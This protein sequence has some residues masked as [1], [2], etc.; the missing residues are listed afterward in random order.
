MEE[1]PSH[2]NFIPA[3][4]QSAVHTIESL[5][6]LVE[7]E[8]ELGVVTFQLNKLLE[9]MSV[10]FYIL[11]VEFPFSAKMFSQPPSNSC[12]NI[13]RTLILSAMAKSHF[14]IY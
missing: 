3:T 9:T 5:L 10:L 8:I 4:H 11:P 13:F 14:S 12:K 7:R 2:L 1:K 6:K